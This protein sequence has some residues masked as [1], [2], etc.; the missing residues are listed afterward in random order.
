MDEE[1]GSKSICVT[2]LGQSVLTLQE[3]I[4]TFKVNS[5]MY[6]IKLN[7]VEGYR[8]VVLKK[9]NVVIDGETKLI[10]M[11]NDVTEKVRFE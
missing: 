11:I 2:E 8:T 7:G 6:N 4:Q 10:I 5:S 1:E 3:V 9:N